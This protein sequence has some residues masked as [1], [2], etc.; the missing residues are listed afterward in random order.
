MPDQELDL[1]VLVR[2]PA[3]FPT[4]SLFGY[5]LRLAEENGYRTPHN[6]LALIGNRDYTFGS[7]RIP[8]LNLARVA[9][10]QLCELERIAYFS[11]PSQRYVV[12]GNPV[13]WRELRRC[14]KVS[15]CPECVRS[16]GFIEAHWDLE[17]MTG[18]PV[19][20]CLPLSRCPKCQLRLRWVRPGQLECSC[21][22][23]CG[24][25][26]GPTLPDDVA[27]LLDIIR[28]KVLGLPVSSQSSTGIPLSQLSALSLT[29]L[30]SLIRTL[31]KFQL[32]LKS[33][34]Q[35]RDSQA[36]LTAAAHVLRSFPD[37]FHKLLW[38]I[39]EQS[40]SKRCGGSVR[41]QFSNIYF[42]V[43]YRCRAGDALETRDF[44]RH[45]FLDFAINQWRRGAITP[46]LLARLQRSFPKRFITTRE[47]GKRYGLGRNTALRVLEM[48]SIPIL[49]IH[50]GQLKHKLVDLDQLHGP[51]TIAKVFGL[52]KASAAIGVSA[53]VLNRLRESGHF[54]VKYSVKGKFLRRDGYHE[55]DVNHF[56]QRLL[57]LN[58]NPMNTTLPR[59]CITL[60]KAMWR[61]HVTDES[62]ANII[63]GLL[64]GELRVL[65]NVDGTVR[66]LILSRAEF[67]QFAYNERARENSNARTAREVAQE[68]HCG[69]HCIRW[70]VEHSLLDG[71]NM[72]R[73][74][75]ISEQSITKFKNKYVSLVSIAREIGSRRTSGLMGY[76]EAK[77]IP[78]VV[79]PFHGSREAFVRIKDRNAVLSYRP[80]RVWNQRR[81][82]ERMRRL[83]EK[84]QDRLKVLLEVRKGDMTK[85]Q[86]AVELGV[87]VTRV[88]Q[89]L[90]RW[91]VG[92]DS[93][94][95]LGL[96][97]RPSKRKPSGGGE[98]ASRGTMRGEK[99]GQAANGTAATSADP[100][101]LNED[102]DASG[103]TQA[104]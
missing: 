64:S 52:I 53:K 83:M 91:R 43:F 19:H 95:R 86:A 26:D 58:P 85:K 35:L 98:T 44:L 88:C 54:E 47:F 69:V 12:L 14:A 33:R 5:I 9:H 87:S 75:R 46:Q 45:A 11:D 37:N 49:T 3:P 6:I 39:G 57:A 15:L 27:E 60:Y 102:F 40:V 4:E 25:V 90:V 65:G 79:I 99:A 80:L 29:G 1:D 59:D 76:C 96:G 21:G 71:W 66:G 73:A 13:A 41:D 93:A 68:I 20:R 97:G 51:P 22:T 30:L 50:T 103:Q 104:A 7:R 38:T 81:S 89:L 56:M 8:L 2:H 78:M 34:K 23:I 100:S 63:R 84:E 61:Y 62:R 55:H 48:N 77:H 72:P 74:S 18:C 24:R 17:L 16:E 32:Q 94:L 70:L 82:A 92:G 67:Q 101:A 42:G 28:R 10:R 31:A 36:V